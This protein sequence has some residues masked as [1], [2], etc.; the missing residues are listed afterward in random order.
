MLDGSSFAVFIFRSFYTA[1]FTK[2][3][4]APYTYRMH[5]PN[6]YT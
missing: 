1:M 5:P 6:I 3:D 2:K 4:I